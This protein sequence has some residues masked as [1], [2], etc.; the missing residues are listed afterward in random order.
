MATKHFVLLKLGNKTFGPSKVSTENCSDVD[1]F[2]EAIKNKFSPFLD[3]YT[4]IQL[5]LFEP[6]G[7]TYIDPETEMTE[8]FITKGKPLIVTVEIPVETTQKPSI[9]TIRHRDYK[10]SKALHSSRSFLTSIAVELQKIYPIPVQTLKQKKRTV[11]FGNVICEAYET[12]PEPKPEFRNKVKNRL[13]NFFTVDEWNILE[14]LNNCVNPEMHNVLAFLNDRISK[15]VILPIEFSHL[16][17]DYQRIA[18]KSNI[19]TEASYLVVK[20][21]GSVSGG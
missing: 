6:D 5:N 4:A 13:N 11:T 8:I 7:T 14:E 16:G 20:N 9:S 1:D 12:N 2:K 10:H 17:P 19:V 18:E 21:E 3:S 15:E